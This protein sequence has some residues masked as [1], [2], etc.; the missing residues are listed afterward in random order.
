LTIDIVPNKYSSVPDLSDSDSDDEDEEDEE[1]ASL[2]AA[3]EAL[4]KVAAKIKEAEER[5]S[6][7]RK[8]LSL[9]EQYASTVATSTS[10]T[11]VPDPKMMKDT[12]ELY[13]AQRAALFDAITGFNE[14]LVELEKERVKKTKLLDKEK[15]AFNKA[16]RVKAEERKKR[17]ADKEERRREKQES[18]P[19]QSSHVHRVR[20]TIELPSSDLTAQESN[21]DAAEVFQEA[22]LTL[23]YTTTSASWTPHYDLRLDTTNPSLSALTYR[24]HFTNQTYETWSQAAITLSTSQASFGGLKEKIPQMEGWRVVLARKYNAMVG[25]NGLYSLAELK[26]KKEAEE[27]EYGI[28]VVQA[29][30]RAQLIDQLSKTGGGG[31]GPKSKNKSVG[32]ILQRQSRSA[33]TPPPMVSAQVALPWRAASSAAYGHGG[34]IKS[35]EEASESD[36]DMGFGLF[37]GGDETT[38][39]PGAKAIQHSLAGSDTYG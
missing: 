28:E 11:A 24:A 3:S 26:A 16:T 2:K 10:S 35:A 9:V 17:K 12:L 21:V 19:Q 29:R 27:K 30:D 13:N 37:E 34:T 22:T 5:R 7:A 38:L 39:A 15:R 23:T 36:V 25:E 4:E 14:K 33:P 18:K 32:G 31:G 1:P 6:S 20:I 8:E